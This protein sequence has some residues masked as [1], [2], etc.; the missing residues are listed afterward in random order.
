MTLHAFVVSIIIE[1]KN[2]F[3]TYGVFAMIQM[4]IMFILYFLKKNL[5]NNWTNWESLHYSTSGSKLPLLLAVLKWNMVSNVHSQNPV[6]LI[7]NQANRCLSYDYTIRR[8]TGHLIYT[9]ICLF[10]SS[11]FDIHLLN[12]PLWSYFW[13]YFFHGMVL[14]GPHHGLPLYEIWIDEVTWK[15]VQHWL[16]SRIGEKYAQALVTR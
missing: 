12:K 2:F 1:Q 3:Y 8:I 10:M 11:I 5:E 9:Q 4:F 13:F 6:K 15:G 7:P 16:I 14:E